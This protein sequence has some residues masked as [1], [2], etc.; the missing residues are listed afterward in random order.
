LVDTPGAYY[1]ISLDSQ[2]QIIYAGIGEPRLETVKY[3]YKFDS[4][5][6]DYK[7]FLE[8]LVAIH[9]IK[10]IYKH[11]K[12]IRVLPDPITLKIPLIVKNTND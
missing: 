5:V 6:N 7:L 1:W 12:L 4:H 8:H 2:N 9:R 10:N 11:F 3:K